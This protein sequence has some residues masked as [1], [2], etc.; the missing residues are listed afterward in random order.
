MPQHIQRRRDKTVRPVLTS[1]VGVGSHRLVCILPRAASA[2]PA[3][4]ATRTSISLV[5]PAMTGTILR[6]A[7]TAGDRGMEV[8]GG[9]EIF[10]KRAFAFAFAARGVRNWGWGEPVQVDS[11]PVSAILAPQDANIHARGLRF[12]SIASRQV[13]HEPHQYTGAV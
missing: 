1:G 10:V 7:V 2:T 8:S 11:S 12:G 6:I 13:H 9:V 5:P 4:F 3:A